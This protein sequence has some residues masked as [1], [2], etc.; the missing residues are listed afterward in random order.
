MSAAAGACNDWCGDPA[1]LRRI[2]HSAER[3]GGIML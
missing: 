2:H 3:T 1:L